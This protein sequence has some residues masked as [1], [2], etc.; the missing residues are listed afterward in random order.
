MAIQKCC[1]P[2]ESQTPTAINTEMFEPVPADS[3]FSTLEWWVKSIVWSIWYNVF[4]VVYTILFLCTL[5]GII[6]RHALGV[7]DEVAEREALE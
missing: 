2:T 7:I 3:T 1:R 5:C 6:E 4:P